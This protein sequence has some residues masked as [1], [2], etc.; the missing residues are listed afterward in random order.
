M[1]VLLLVVGAA[2]MI[3]RGGNLAYTVGIAKVDVQAKMRGVLDWI[4]MDVRQA[5]SWD[6]ANNVPTPTHIKFRRVQNV[7]TATGNYILEATF[8][9]YDYDGNTDI[10]TRRIVNVDG[11]VVNALTF[12]DIAAFEFSTIDNNG[13][14][15]ALN[16]NDLRNSRRLVITLT[17]HVHARTIIINVPLS[18][19]V[20]VRNG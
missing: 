11:T 15:V 18:E 5:P 3:M 9:E 17:G 1:S 16:E 10:L 20:K 7:D 14:T 4:T 13:I 6:I 12:S 8:V 2:V 19:E